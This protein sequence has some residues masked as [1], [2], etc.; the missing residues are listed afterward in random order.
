MAVPYPVRCVLRIH[1]LWRVHSLSTLLEFRKHH[2]IDPGGLNI[3]Q[4]SAKMK[5][6]LVVSIAVLF[7][8]SWFS[9]PA[10]TR[11]SSVPA[12][13]VVEDK[14][15]SA[16]RCSATETMLEGLEFLTLLSSSDNPSRSAGWRWDTS[17]WKL[18]INKCRGCARPS[19][20]GALRKCRVNHCYGKRRRRRKG[21]KKTTLTKRQKRC[22]DCERPKGTVNFRRCRARGCY[23]KGGKF[24][25]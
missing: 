16:V 10:A 22:R 24:L 17:H 13:L 1:H 8:P 3:F 6:F 12:S 7:L 9:I 14:C 18:P 4:A 23:R 15:T 25:P 5:T 21:R 11:L 19:S 20:N 2:V